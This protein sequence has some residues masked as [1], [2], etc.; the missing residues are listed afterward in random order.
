MPFHLG[1]TGKFRYIDSNED[2]VLFVEAMDQ[3]MIKTSSDDQTPPAVVIN[4]TVVEQR[5]YDLKFSIDMY[6]SPKDPKASF[7]IDGELP[8]SRFKNNPP[9]NLMNQVVNVMGRL[10]E[11]GFVNAFLYSTSLY[12]SSFFRSKSRTLPNAATK[13]LLPSKLLLQ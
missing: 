6:F 7:K 8:S 2:C 13:L 3:P 10:T 4:A 12:F 11:P 1:V 5:G 9:P